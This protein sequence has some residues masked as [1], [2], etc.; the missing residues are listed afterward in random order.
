MECVGAGVTAGRTCVE[1][2]AFTRVVLYTTSAAPE[3]DTGASLAS[4]YSSSHAITIPANMAQY[5]NCIRLACL[6]VKLVDLNNLDTLFRVYSLD[7]V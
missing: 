2:A 7:Y 6:F 5:F 4:I 1:T 3:M